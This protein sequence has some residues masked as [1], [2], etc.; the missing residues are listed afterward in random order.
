MMLIHERLA[1]AYAE[2]FP[3]KL[4]EPATDLALLRKVMV[5]TLRQDADPG[6]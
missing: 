5:W 1:R 3:L 6:L 4:L 2:Q